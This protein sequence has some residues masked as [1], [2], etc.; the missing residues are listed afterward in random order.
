M[1]VAFDPQTFSLQRYGGIS[2]YFFETALRLAAL[3]DTRVS[4]LAFAHINA[5]L[6]AASAAAVGF[7]LPLLPEPLRPL[8]VRANQALARRW[9]ARNGADLVHE[10]YYSHARTAP[11]GVPT[12]VT[13]HDMIHEKFPDYAP[14]TRK[15]AMAKRAAI[16]RADHVICVSENTRHDLVDIYGIDPSR[17]TVVRHGFSFR[18]SETAAVHRP[19][20][21]P[22]VLFIGKRGGYKNFEALARAYA[23]LS[24]LA[25]EHLLVCFGDAPFSRRERDFLRRLGIPLDRVRHFAGG[26]DRLAA[27]YRHAAVF[28]YPSRYEGFGMPP[29]EAMACDCPVVCSNAASLPEVVG[30]AAIAFD[31][32]DVQALAAAIGAVLESPDTALRLRQAGRARL[33]RFSWERCA[34]Q[35]RAVYARVLA[36]R[37]TRTG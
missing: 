21:E 11:A 7:R 24:G 9:L 17:T 23:Q 31:P 12:V 15:I 36:Q 37:Q 30:D 16:G 25:R 13:V 22:Y 29:L 19:L 20:G 10:T 3:P 14:R 8:L 28:V 33:A 2:R 26:D 18:F 35:T 1:H 4:I 27:F 32:G 34:Q 5:Y 6:A